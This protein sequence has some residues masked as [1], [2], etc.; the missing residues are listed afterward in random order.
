MLPRLREVL[1][2]QTR[3]TFAS[4]RCLCHKHAGVNR[5]TTGVNFKASTQTPYSNQ[6]ITNSSFVIKGSH[7]I[8]LYLTFPTTTVAIGSNDFLLKSYSKSEGLLLSARVP[9]SCGAICHFLSCWTA[10]WQ[11][12][13]F[14]VQDAHLRLVRP[15]VVCDLRFW[16]LWNLWRGLPADWVSPIL[17]GEIGVVWDLRNQY[18]HGKV[19]TWYHRESRNKG[20]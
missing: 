14:I 6:C 19:L 5:T 18:H 15:Y 8:R 17:K 11:P 10:L 3:L 16:H 1:D 12:Q 7:F 2:F 13:A 4:I 9:L 20:Y